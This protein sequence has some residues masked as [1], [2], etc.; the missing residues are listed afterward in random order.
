LIDNRFSSTDYRSPRNRHASAYSAE[1]SKPISTEG[2][3]ILKPGFAR[4]FPLAKA[5]AQKIK[6]RRRVIWISLKG[7]PQDDYSDFVIY[8]RQMGEPLHCQ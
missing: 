2:S 8:L 1:M 5:H 6:E 7:T 4:L 3:L